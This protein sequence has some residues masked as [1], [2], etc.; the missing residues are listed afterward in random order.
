MKTILKYI[1][2][3]MQTMY[4][5]SKDCGYLINDIRKGGSI[6]EKQIRLS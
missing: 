1:Y 3:M 5:L 6:W 4:F 2:Y